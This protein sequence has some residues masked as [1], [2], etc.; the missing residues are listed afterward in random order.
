MK[1]TRNTVSDT[2]KD[3]VKFLGLKGLRWNGLQRDETVFSI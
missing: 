1:L 3:T 2:V